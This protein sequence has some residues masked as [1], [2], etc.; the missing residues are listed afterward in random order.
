MP[1]GAITYVHPAAAP[2]WAKETFTGNSGDQRQYGWTSHYSDSAKLGAP[3][4]DNELVVEVQLFQLTEDGEPV[5][6]LMRFMGAEDSG[7]ENDL[8]AEQTDE[9]IARAEL[10]LAK[11]RGLRAHMDQAEHQAGGE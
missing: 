7:V 10:W 2:S 1:T 8:T 6:T 5:Q 11:V 9:L 3:G 4:P